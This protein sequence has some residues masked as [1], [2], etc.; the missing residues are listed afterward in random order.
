MKIGIDI[1]GSHIG[2]G[3]V[4]DQ[5]L[6]IR[7]KEHEWTKTEKKNLYDNMIKYC[8]D[9]I[10]QICKEENIDVHQIESVGIG[11]PNK[12]IKDGIIYTPERKINIPREIINQY[13]I[14][15]YLKNDV[16]CS[17]LC[18][19]TIGNLKDYNNALFITLGTGIG[20]AYYYQNKL[21]VPNTYQGFEVGH[22]II[23]AGG[24]KCRCGNRGCFEEYASMN[25]F[26]SKFKKL[27]NLEKVN[28]KIVLEIYKSKEK[29]E[30]LL[31]IIEK[32]IE[33][34][35]IGLSNLIYIFEPDAICIGGSFV[36]YEEIFLE[37][38]KISLK[39][40]FKNREIPSILLAKYAN[41]AGIIGASMLESN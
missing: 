13:N 35:S 38:L 18:E 19:K 20:G 37:K 12:K 10:E 14:K 26:R 40:K 4:N 30:E 39:E 7:K 2:V 27:Y 41:D 15:S 17:G 3:I 34:L 29:E 1:G 5:N 36:H 32:Y 28:S 11:F 33:Y 23:K 8:I 31:K 6:I 25:A 24:K 22:M 16:K 9:Y 21:V